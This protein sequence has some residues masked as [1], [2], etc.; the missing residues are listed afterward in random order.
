[1]A[2]A[3]TGGLGFVFAIGAVPGMLF[4]EPETGLISAIIYL[5]RP[6]VGR[7]MSLAGVREK[8]QVFPLGALE[9][10]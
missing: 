4:A 3:E 6:R 5:T 8:S 7:I 9:E 2:G 1:L 10:V